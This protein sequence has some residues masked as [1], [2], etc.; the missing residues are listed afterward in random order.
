[1]ALQALANRERN[2]HWPTGNE[3]STGQHRKKLGLANRWQNKYWPTEKE[4]STGQWR[5]KLAL[6]NRE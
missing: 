1:M 2:K 4:I 5:T 3:I 6:A